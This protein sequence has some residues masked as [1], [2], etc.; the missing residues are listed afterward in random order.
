MRTAPL[1]L[2]RW[3]RI[4]R[5]LYKGAL[6]A[7]AGQL[8]FA[9]DTLTLGSRGIGF[10]LT[11]NAMGHYILSVVDFPAAPVTLGSGSPFSACFLE[12]DPPR[13]RPNSEKGGICLPFTDEGLCTF[14]N[15]RAFSACKAVTLGDARVGNRSGSSLRNC[16]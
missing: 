8:D 3:M 14:A 9:R 2:L 16:M 6:A 7:L 11:V 15:P 12:L 13:K 4:F 10:S 5:L 1:Q